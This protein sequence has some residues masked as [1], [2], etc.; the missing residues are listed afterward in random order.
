MAEPADTTDADEDGGGVAAKEA[1]DELGATA[2]MGPDTQAPEVSGA[3]TL[4]FNIKRMTFREPGD[5]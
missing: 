2:E 4:C 1:G 3:F 5:F